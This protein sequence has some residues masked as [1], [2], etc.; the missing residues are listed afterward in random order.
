MKTL[1]KSL[2]SILTL[3]AIVLAS[4]FASAEDWK[5]EVGHTITLYQKGSSLSKQI[6]SLESYGIIAHSNLCSSSS[7]GTE[8]TCFDILVKI[9]E[10]SQ[11]YGEFISLLDK[12]AEKQECLQTCNM[13]GFSWSS[14]HYPVPVG[15]DHII[16]RLASVKNDYS[17]SMKDVMLKL[18]YELASGSD[19][20]ETLSEEFQRLLSGAQT[21]Y[22]EGKNAILAVMDYLEIPHD[23]L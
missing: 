10:A 17:T 21:A 23:E 2:K 19:A 7:F 5:T 22:E 8:E 15:I 4:N 12:F 14:C 3:G 6:G 1:T 9:E 13:L 16:R 18:N 20:S 11:W